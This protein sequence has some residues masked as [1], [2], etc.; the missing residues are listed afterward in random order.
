MSEAVSQKEVSSQTELT[1]MGSDEHSHKVLL[2]AE[3]H[4][5]LQILLWENGITLVV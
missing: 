4:G 5:V 2:L 3:F 1:V